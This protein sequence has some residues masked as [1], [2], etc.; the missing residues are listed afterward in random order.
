M[1]YIMFHTLLRI[2]MCGK[3]S[4]ILLDLLQRY[5]FVALTGAGMSTESGIPDYRG[6]GTLRR[7]RQPMRYR[8]F[9]HDP[10]ARR[11]YWARSTV[12]WPRIAQARPNPGHY[13][14]AEL[15]ATGYLTGVITQNVDGLHQQAGS[16]RIVELHGSLADVCCLTCGM[17]LSRAVLQQRLLELNPA[18][19]VRDAL[20]A[21]DGDADIPEALLTRF[22]VPA[23]PRCEGVLKPH[24]VFFGE[25]V[26]A[27]RVEA[28][29]GLF[30]QAEALL[31]CGSSLTV[32]SGY[33]FVLQAAREGKPVVIVNLGSTRGDHFACLRI[34]RRTGQFLPWL[35][36]RM[37]IKDLAEQQEETGPQ[38]MRFMGS[39]R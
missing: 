7:A 39:S 20:I 27:C 29:W 12:G 22:R 14:L 38:S 26:P 23:C 24:V 5:R 34:T 1:Y 4:E 36:H 10:E 37:G 31:V 32:Y 25:N 6:P 8:Q 35:V 33:R 30:D 13:A 15:E 16:R 3:D 19:S 18:F 28:A 9:I 11:R 21:P 17:R 2:R